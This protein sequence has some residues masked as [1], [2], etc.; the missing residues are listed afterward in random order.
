[1]P[2]PVLPAMH[3]QRCVA[4]GNMPGAILHMKLPSKRSHDYISPT[5]AN[6]LRYLAKTQ[7]EGESRRLIEAG[8]DAIE[9]LDKMYEHQRFQGHQLDKLKTSLVQA[10]CDLE[11]LMPQAETGGG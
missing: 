11:Q 10:A 5:D 1:M 3:P 6:R 7:F 8:A 2:D 9:N 4:C